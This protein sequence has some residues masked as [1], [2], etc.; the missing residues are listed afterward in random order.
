M[1]FNKPNTLNLNGNIAEN[2]KT[3]REEVLIYFSAT[4][5]EKKPKLVQVARLKNLLG[6]EALKLYKTLNPDEENDETVLSILNVL[7]EHCLPQKNEIVDIFNFF[8][9]K[10]QSNEPFEKFYADLK[11][12]IKPCGFGD[13][14]KK[15]LRAQ[16]VLGIKS[17]N[18]KE[19]L[20][21]EDI[22]LEKTISYCKS[23][24]TAETNIQEMERKV[25]NTVELN[26]V[27]NSDGEQDDEHGQIN[28]VNNMNLAKPG[29]RNVV[30]YKQH[31]KSCTRCGYTH[32]KNCPAYG[33]TCNKCQ[34]P[35]HFATMCR[36]N[37]FSSSNKEVKQCQN[38]DFNIEENHTYSVSS[39]TQSV[40]QI[41]SWNEVIKV[42]G[43]NLQFK[44]DTGA[45]VNVLPLS[46][47]RDNKLYPK[48]EK[49]NVRLQAFGGFVVEPVGKIKCLVES[50]RKLCNVEFLIV[51]YCQNPIIGLNAC[52][53]LDL[54]KKVESLDNKDKSEVYAQNREVF[55]GLGCFPDSCTI[56]LDQNA[57]P[58]IS[59]A[60]RI[61]LKIRDQF[62]VTLENLVKKEIITPVSEPVEWVNNV[63]I[64][65]KPN[66][67]LRICIDPIELNKYIIREKYTIPTLE[68]LAPKLSNK[69]VFTVLDIKDGFYHVK[70]DNESSKLCSFST[71]YGT[72]RFLRAPFGLSCMPEIFQRLVYKYFGDIPG[73]SIYFDDLCIAGDSKDE[74]DQILKNVLERARKYNIRFN[75][76]KL[77]YCVNEV[78]YLGV[79][80]N[81]SG[82]S[83]D[84]EKTKSIK[85]LSNPTNKNELQQLLGL[86]NYLRNFI[87]NLAELTTP[88][89]ELLKKNVQWQW[90]ESHTK[91][92]NTLKQIICSGQVLAA[93]D[94][95]LPIDIQ[96]DASKDA[97]G[98]C[99]L[100]NG[101]PVSFAS[102]CLNNAEIQYAQIEKELLAITFACNKF[103]YYIYG[104]QNVTVHTDHMPLLSILN[105]DMNDIK[106]NRLKRLKLKL[107]DYSFTLKYLPGKKMYIADLLSRN[108]VRAPQHYYDET[109]NDYIHTVSVCELSISDDKKKELQESTKN[110]EVL[111]VVLQWYTNGW[112]SKCTEYGEIKHYFNL[113]NELC[114]EDGLFYYNNRLIVPSNFRKYFLQLFH[115][116][117]TGIVKTKMIVKKYFYWP[118]LM[119]DIESYISG[120]SLCLKYSR[121]NTQDPLINHNIPE[122]P[123]N[124]VGIDIAEHA[125]Q[126]YLIL[127]DYFSKW[128]EIIKLNTKTS[129][130][131][132]KKL[133]NVFSRNGIPAIVITDNM[134]FNSF[135]LKCFAEEWKFQICT[136][137]PHHPKSNGMA[138]K[139]VHIAKN[140]LKKAWEERK[141][142][143][144]YL[145]NYR[146]TPLAGLNVSPAQLLMNRN[147]RTKLPVQQEFFKPEIVQNHVYEKM[148]EN[149]K[150][151]KTYY[152]HRSRQNN[153]L[154]ER[155]ENVLVQNVHNRLWENGVITEKLNQPRSYMVKM[156]KDGN[157]L[158]RNTIH[159]KKIKG[160]DE[161]FQQQKS[162]VIPK[163]TEQQQHQL[164]CSDRKRQPPNRLNL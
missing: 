90:T 2:F 102:R 148:M 154:Y 138:E 116:T 75:F 80:F 41:K 125:G 92:L 93:F 7:G 91:S 42:E 26:E 65:E 66:G 43:V 28:T 84:P 164:R 162:T 99:I 72:Y 121:S 78:K 96:C 39:I 79:I 59:A 135:E 86:I 15:L 118:G 88:F 155:G 140:M 73:V 9:R 103:H 4:E 104:Q 105:K 58:K 114:L 130:E 25:K 144:L 63:V 1:E 45:E 57:K 77:Q 152:D 150:T 133:K 14:E 100:Q 64:V 37:R 55:D 30:Q 158:R 145:L 74:V 163:S 54:I 123:F 32:D 33:K 71:V 132:I 10:Q 106:N 67:S 146:N 149:Q 128:L 23:V 31:R 115:E 8:T 120:C 124:K 38:L 68:E 17:K 147:L 3:F 62:K 117:H 113:K 49:C 126:S 81:K 36:T 11:H 136:S 48:L 143:Q 50:K 51:K 29:N 111:K 83:P 20:L 94:E 60:R 151:Q 69:Q 82:M 22:S 160:K 6:S 142:I 52:I 47:I 137:S 35:N 5:T 12:L 127:I 108:I 40:N 56:R 34:K 131:V 53:E 16:I 153:M 44:L 156:S 139:G 87:P 122:I 89:R 107:I 141:D 18:M 21:R 101:K 46:F 134:P 112:P 70:L 129:S 110:D 27:V 19:R 61:P 161:R 157:I 119:S 13:Q 97:I 24:E 98:C 95:K 76:D 109:M 85:T 159:L